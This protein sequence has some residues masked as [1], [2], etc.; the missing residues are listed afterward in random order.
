MSN[1]TAAPVP[2][3]SSPYDSF[4][5]AELSEWLVSPNHP[6]ADAERSSNAIQERVLELGHPLSEAELRELYIE[7]IE[8]RQANGSM[9]VRLDGIPNK[10]SLETALKDLKIYLRY[11]V[12][13]DMPEIKGLR[14]KHWEEFT[15]S[16]DAELRERLASRFYFEVVRAKGAN[17]RKPAWWSEARWKSSF[18]A[19][20]FDNQVDPFLT[21]YLNKLPAWDGVKRVETCFIDVFGADDTPLNRHAGRSYWL[22]MVQRTKQPGC[23]LDE[24]TVLVGGQGW[25]K[26][27]FLKESLPEQTSVLSWFSDGLRLSD[28]AKERAE[29]LQGRVVVEISEMQGATR[30]EIEELKA[31]ITQQDDGVQR[32]A[33]RKNPQR[34]LRRCVIAATTNSNTCLPNDPTGLRRFIPVQL[35]HGANIEKYMGANR[36]QCMAEALAMYKD[37]KRANLP[38]ALMDAQKEVAEEYRNADLTMEDRVAN[39]PAQPDTTANLGALLLGKSEYDVGKKDEMRI[40]KALGIA[41]WE[42]NRQMWQGKR[43]YLWSPP[44]GWQGGAEG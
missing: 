30:P 36:D 38:R 42:K 22:G 19:I 7:L 25:G 37:G 8:K 13:S 43:V 27:T 2:V 32:F 18:W 14:G 34:R 29:A 41:G 10:R 39:L 23:K 24:I 16:H 44:E 28:G 4:S 40:A 12:R 5:T 33:F 17:D 6:E 21:E 20:M 35:K 26:S 15:D 9:P 11:N 31:F 1:P 3:Q